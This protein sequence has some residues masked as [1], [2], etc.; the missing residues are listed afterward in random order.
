MKEQLCSDTSQHVKGSLA[1]AICELAEFVPRKDA[2]EEIFPAVINILTKDSVTE[3]RV[4]LLESLP[5][6]AQ[7]L[8]EDATIEMVIPEIEKLSADP[9]WRVRLA[10]IT[11]IPK[12]LAFITPHKFTEKVLPIIKVY[13]RDSVH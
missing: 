5:K 7:S 2:I 3:V 6:L 4:S 13:Q 10:T 12:F 11:F 9:T 8:G 1:S